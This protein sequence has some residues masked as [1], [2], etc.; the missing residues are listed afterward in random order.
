[1]SCLI[2]LPSGPEPWPT[3]FKLIFFS[4]ANVLAAGLAKTRP[5]L[6]VLSWVSYFPD[7]DYTYFFDFFGFS[8]ASYFSAF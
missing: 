7:L 1:M 6:P 3:S 2:I 4:P 8:S 5:S